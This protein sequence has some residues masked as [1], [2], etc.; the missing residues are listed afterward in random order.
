MTAIIGLLIILMEQLPPNSVV[1]FS[2]WM[3]PSRRA[4]DFVGVPFS[5]LVF[6]G[7]ESPF[8]WQ[9]SQG[10]DSRWFEDTCT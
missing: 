2:L 8:C 5:R 1:V 6:Q 3:Y 9:K 4:H 10:K 7:P